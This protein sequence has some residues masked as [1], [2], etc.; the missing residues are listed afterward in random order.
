MATLLETKLSEKPAQTKNDERALTKEQQDKLNQQKIDIR[1]E[2][3]RYL[4]SHP[5]ISALIGGF[6][7]EVVLQQP[8][9]IREFAAEYFNDPALADKVRTIQHENSH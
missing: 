5:E 9:D 7:S 6:V 2:N 8:K 4:R 3:E 1:I